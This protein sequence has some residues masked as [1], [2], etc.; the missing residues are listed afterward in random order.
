M[1]LC[2]SYLECHVLFEW[3]LTTLVKAIDRTST[4]TVVLAVVVAAGVAGGGGASPAAAEAEPPE[5][6]CRFPMMLPSE[7]NKSYNIR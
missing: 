1:T 5:V 2:H 3:P 6:R 4:V 7:V